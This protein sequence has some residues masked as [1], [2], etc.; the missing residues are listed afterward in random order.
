LFADAAARGVIVAAA[1]TPFPG[2][3]Y[4]ERSGSG[5]AWAPLNYSSLR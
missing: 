4:I 2:L 3:G 1:H 5:Y